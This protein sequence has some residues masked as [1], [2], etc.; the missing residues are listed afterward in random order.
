M[1]STDEIALPLLPSD[2]NISDVEV[3][4]DSGFVTCN[5]LLSL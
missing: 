5:L 2:E 3:G 4:R 1:L